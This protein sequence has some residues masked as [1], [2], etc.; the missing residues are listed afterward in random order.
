MF[1]CLAAN[2]LHVETG[3]IIRNVDDHLRA[4]AM[5]PNGDLARRR[6]A[7]ALTN[8]GLFDAVDDGIAEHVFERWQHLLEH[9]AVEF[10]GGSFDREFGPLAGLLG[11]LPHQPGQARHVPFE[12]HHARAHQAVLQFRGHA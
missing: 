7:I 1:V 9:L 6:L 2:R 4:F 12:R 5:Q 8:V 3:A 11:D 10:P